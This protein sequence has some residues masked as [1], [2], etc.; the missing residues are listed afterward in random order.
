MAELDRSAL[1]ARGPD[2]SAIAW[3]SWR[4]IE[5]FDGPMD[6]AR[7][8]GA[9]LDLGIT[10]LDT[11]EVYGGYATEA[12]LG[13]GL[14]ELGGEA[15][16]FEIITKCGIAVKSQTR[17]EH[18]VKH[19]NS[20][21]AHIQA[22]AEAS[23]ARLGRERI[24]VLLIHRPDILMN[25]KET[26]EA[27]DKL[28][29]AGTIGYAG[30]SNF[31]VPQIE[32]LHAAINNPLVTNQIELSPLHLDPIGDGTLDQAQR[33]GFRPMLWSP[34]GGGSLFTSDVPRAARICAALEGVAKDYGLGIG[35]KG[36]GPAAIAWLM[37]H[38]SNPVPVVGTSKL[39]RLKALVAAANV[40][41]DR[42]DWYAVFEAIL[43]RPVA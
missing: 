34:F 3:G 5:Q 36:A 30:V 25:A 16:H 21:A 18:R 1:S 11:A 37:R 4:A 26:A 23:C 7:F 8:L 14:A 19:Y 15:E 17:P 33:L 29:R 31:T 28:I 9:I 12:F 13:K 10:T 43:G 42:Q 40:R 32:L 39:D 22:S 27:L 41:L 24:D 20:S 6:L 38:P 35:R 2:V